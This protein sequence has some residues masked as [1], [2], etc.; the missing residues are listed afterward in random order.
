M[1]I[2]DTESPEGLFI[3][4]VEVVKGNGHDTST[5]TIPVLTRE[6]AKK[7]EERHEHHP[8]RSVFK[9]RKKVACRPEDLR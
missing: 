8:S 4:I 1:T 6:L 7:I 5:E 3:W 2:H 9:T